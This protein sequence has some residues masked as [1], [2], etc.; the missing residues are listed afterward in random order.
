MGLDIT[1]NNKNV[2][3]RGYISF[4]KL[5]CA[6]ADAACLS[7][8]SDWYMETLLRTKKSEELWP[9][10]QKELK[11]HPLR[12]FLLHSDC[13]GYIGVNSARKIMPY[14]SALIDKIDEDFKLELE[15]LVDG[16]K[17]SIEC[18]AKLIFG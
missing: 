13:E 18:N 8:Y 2:Y 4:G 14:L 15:Y 11:G 6:I 12:M 1:V 5:R 17:E 10:V 9:I 16:F 3:H 7:T